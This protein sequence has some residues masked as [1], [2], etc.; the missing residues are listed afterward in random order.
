M[1]RSALNVVSA[2]IDRMFVRRMTISPPAGRS[3]SQTDFA[4]T[5]DLSRSAVFFDIASGSAVR[6]TVRRSAVA[7]GSSFPSTQAGGRLPTIDLLNFQGRSGSRSLPAG[8]SP[9]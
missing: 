3:A 2:W 1:Y 9:V 6:Q 5:P 8:L 4:D 7:A